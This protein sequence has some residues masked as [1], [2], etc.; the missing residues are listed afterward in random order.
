MASCLDF[1]ALKFLLESL[2]FLQDL[3]ED[4]VYSVLETGVHLAVA[5]WPDQHGGVREAVHSGRA[6]RGGRLWPRL[7]LH[8][9]KDRLSICSKDDPDKSEWLQGPGLA[10]G[11]ATAAD[12]L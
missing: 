2:H 6:A 1:V 12:L 3:R 11:D 4:C 10:R 7:P 8:A 9:Q 5:L